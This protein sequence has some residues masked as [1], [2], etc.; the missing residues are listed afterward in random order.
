[1]QDGYVQHDQMLIPLLRMLYHQ[2]NAITKEMKKVFLS[3]PDADWWLSIPGTQGPL[4]PARM[5]AWMGDN[6]SRFPT[7]KVLQAVAGTVPVTRRSGKTKVVEFRTACSHPL[8][9]AI[10]DLA[11]QSTRHSGWARAYFQQQLDKGHSAARSYR[12]L[13]NRWLKIIWT[14]WQRHETYDEA[15]HVANRSRKGQRLPVIAAA[16]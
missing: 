5:L 7:A 16:D 8:R 2:K 1:M 14:L 9:S 15:V 13:S 3:H 11:R 10:D 4:T 6:R 12:A